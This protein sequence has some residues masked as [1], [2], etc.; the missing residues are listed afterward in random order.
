MEDRPL[1][2]WKKVLCQMWSPTEDTQVRKKTT[3]K[4]SNFFSGK[5]K[6]GEKCVPMPPLM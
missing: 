2:P 3:Q 4:S 1:G 5:N 6:K